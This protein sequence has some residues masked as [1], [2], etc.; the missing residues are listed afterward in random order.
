MKDYASLLQ[1]EVGG[2]SFQLEDPL[3]MRDWQDE[4]GALE[5]WPPCMCINISE[6]LMNKDQKNL[7]DRLKNDYKEG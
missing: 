7:L 6:Y 4:R 3:K 2:Q 1:I 5:K